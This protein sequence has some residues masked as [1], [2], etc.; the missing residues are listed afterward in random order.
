M[1]GT[2]KT[3]GRW[4]QT[5]RYAAFVVCVVELAT[6]AS[7]PSNRA[8]AGAAAAFAGIALGLTFAVNRVRLETSDDNRRTPI[9]PAVLL[10]IRVGGPVWLGLAV[11]YA[12]VL[13]W[14]LND[15]DVSAVLSAVAAV[16]LVAGVFV[17][18]RVTWRA[19]GVDRSAL[20]LSAALAF[21]LTMAASV[22]YALFETL[23]GAPA[24]NMWAVWGFGGAT[25]TAS[26]L[27]VSRRLS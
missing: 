15:R 5:W 1:T 18:V 13:M 21:G 10:A 22:S 11:T 19:G 24:L 14:Q 3:S 8:T 26:Y 23:N 12:A 17:G 7:A 2:M 25:W 6:A 27:V 16:A 9:V 20:T 4:A